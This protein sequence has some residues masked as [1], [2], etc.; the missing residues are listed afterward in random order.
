MGRIIEINMSHDEYM[1]ALEDIL[2]DLEEYGVPHRPNYSQAL[3]IAMTYP[4]PDTGMSKI[5][6]KD[7][8]LNNVEEDQ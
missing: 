8:I 7:T 1:T 5:I 3:A 2:T 4:Y 6:A